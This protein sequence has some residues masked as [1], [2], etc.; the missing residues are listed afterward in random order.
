MMLHTFKQQ[1]KIC[2]FQSTSDVLMNS[3]DLHCHLV[4]LWRFNDSGTE[5]KTPYLLTYSHNDSDTDAYPGVF[6]HICF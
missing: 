5:Y 3:S 1:L 2:L 4:L 6:R